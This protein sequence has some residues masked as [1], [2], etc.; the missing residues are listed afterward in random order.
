M[1]QEEMVQ[2]EDS[3]ASLAL[4]EMEELVEQAQREEMVDP[5]V[6]PRVELVD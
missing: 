3:V 6:E 2:L 1:D 4:A 5:V